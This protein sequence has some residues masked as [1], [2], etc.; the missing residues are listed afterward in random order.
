MKVLHVYKTYL[1]DS[2]GGV[3]KVIEQIALNDERVTRHVG[4]S[5]I[6]RLI[7]VPGKL[8]NIVL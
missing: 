7:I 5:E 8:V 1:P 6:K 2:I 3:E 4:E